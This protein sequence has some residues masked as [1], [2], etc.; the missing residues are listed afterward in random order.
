MEDGMVLTGE[1]RDVRILT[2]NKDNKPF[3][4]ECN[5]EIK[6]DYRKKVFISYTDFDLE[7]KYGVGQ[8]FENL[9]VYV[10]VFG[11][12]IVVHPVRLGGNGTEIKGQEKKVSNMKV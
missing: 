5:V 7:K 4:T 3:A 10:E 2:S 9:P 12:N 6:G 1:V 11:K 8:K